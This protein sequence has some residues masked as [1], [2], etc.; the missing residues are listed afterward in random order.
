MEVVGHHVEVVDIL[1]N[2]DNIK[3]LEIPVRSWNRNTQAISGTVL[4]Q[5]AFDIIQQLGEIGKIFA[6]PL[7]VRG[8]GILPVNIH[9]IEAICI[10]KRNKGRNE[11]ALVGFGPGN[12]GKC[13]GGWTGVVERPAT[14]GDEDLQ[15]GV[16]FLLAD[17]L[18][19]ELWIALG[20]RDNLEGLWVD[21]GKGKIDM[22]VDTVG[23]V[24]WLKLIASPPG[25]PAF[26]V[27]H[28]ALHRGVLIRAGRT[29]N[30][31]LATKLLGQT[32]IA[33]MLL[34]GRATAG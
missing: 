31:F 34:A 19:V 11:D 8:L 4:P 3:V 1:G 33:R 18:T 16:N 26:V 24:G 30:L 5:G 12:I 9:A 21:A 15:V 6:T 10:Y 27:A 17:H 29:G 28:H 23:D 7:T 25:G 32:A 20:G 2:L 13:S 22:S 14:N